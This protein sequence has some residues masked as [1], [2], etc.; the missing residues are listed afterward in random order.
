MIKFVSRSHA[1]SLIL[2]ALK[3]EIVGIVLYLLEKKNKDEFIDIVL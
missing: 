2:D 1:G 3:Q